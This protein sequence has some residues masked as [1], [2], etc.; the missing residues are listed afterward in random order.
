MIRVSSLMK[1]KGVVVEV[2]RLTSCVVYVWCYNLEDVY[3]G[4][5]CFN[6]RR[7]CSSCIWYMVLEHRREEAYSAP[8]V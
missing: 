1:P 6:E 5:G 2:D 7:C 3:N 8:V 4:A